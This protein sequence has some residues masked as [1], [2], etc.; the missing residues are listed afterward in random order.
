MERAQEL[1]IEDDAIQSQL[2]KK[3]SWKNYLAEL[4]HTD[5]GRRR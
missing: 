2:Y 4:K 5:P 3:P 1:A